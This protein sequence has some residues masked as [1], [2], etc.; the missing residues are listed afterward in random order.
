ML[1][2]SISSQ[3]LLTEIKVILSNLGMSEMYHSFNF[4]TDI[5]FYMIKHDDDSAA[6]YKKS[7]NLLAEKYA[8]GERTISNG[9]A[10]ILKSCDDSIKSKTQFN[11]TRNSTLNKVRV[12]KNYIKEKL[13]L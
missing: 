13:A 5:I 1:K 11:L 12:I 6:I 10:S 8:V 3:L 2:K 7:L 9:L 4:L